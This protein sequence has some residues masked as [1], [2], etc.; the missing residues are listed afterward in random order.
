MYLSRMLACVVGFIFIVGYSLV[1][2]A[3]VGQIGLIEGSVSITK[4]SGKRILVAEGTNLDIGDVVVT[5]S[6][7]KAMLAFTDGGKISL[8]P[9]TVFQISEYAYQTDKPDED[10]ALFQLLK[11]G[12]RTITGLVGKRGNKE[13]YRLGNNTSTI[14]IRGTEYI[15]RVCDSAGC[16]ED[17]QKRQGKPIVRVNPVARVVLLDG[18]VFREGITTKNERK[19]LL[20]GDPLYTGDTIIT[21]ERA[22]FGM[23]FTDG[24]RIVLPA[25]TEFKVASYQYAKEDAGKDSFVMQVLKGGARVVTGLVGKRNPGKVKY[26]TAT[27]T[28]GIRGTDFD[29]ACLAS[30]SEQEGKLAGT[31]PT[32]PCEQAVATTVREGTVELSSEGGSQPVSQEQSGYVN[33]LKSKPILLSS[34][35]PLFGEDTP[36]PSSLEGDTEKVFGVDPNSVSESGMFVT[37]IEGKVVLQQGRSASLSLSA[38]ES[39]FAGASGSSDALIM[40]NGTPDGNNYDN[41][42]RSVRFDA[43]S[44]GL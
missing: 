44:C 32:T 3:P 9:N 1:Q 6:S 13:A 28:I 10:T 7:S 20:M 17:S 37:V 2:A 25:G 35:T 11:G 39:G 16:D 5:G 12:L 26:Q 33:G 41:F 24:T 36:L 27:S 22:T 8:R 43:F 38:G 34:K 18:L 30:G 21:S 14:G 40:L 15:A 31:P 19:Q 4:A 42:L 23:L 29:M